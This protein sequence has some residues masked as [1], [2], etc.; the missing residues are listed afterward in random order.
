MHTE[1]TA[2]PSTTAREPTASASHGAAA[3]P[4]P[5]AATIS[6]SA[7]P[8][9]DDRLP[10]GARCCRT[11]VATA[12]TYTEHAPATA[13]GATAHR[14]PGERP[15]TARTIPVTSTA[16]RPTAPDSPVCRNNSGT[17]KAPNPTAAVAIP[18]ALAPDDHDSRA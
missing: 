10:S 5:A 4:I 12:S 8:R 9:T 3:E 13:R 1:A 15:I 17:A 18:N 7:R 16:Q 2:Q 6:E 14:M 11:P